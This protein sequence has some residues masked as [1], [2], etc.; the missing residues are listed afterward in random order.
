[1]KTASRKMTVN[2]KCIHIYDV[3]PTCS[4]LVLDLLV[5]VP[6]RPTTYQRQISASGHVAQLAV[7]CDTHGQFHEFSSQSRMLVCSIPTAIKL[8]TPSP[9]L[10]EDIFLSGVC[11]WCFVGFRQH[12]AIYRWRACLNT[13]NVCYSLNSKMCS[14]I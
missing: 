3:L 7:R 9:P 6:P 1:M 13:C 8:S 2:K 5:D 12:R 11:T 14:F 4:V 10:S